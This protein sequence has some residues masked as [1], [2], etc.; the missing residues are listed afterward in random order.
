MYQKLLEVRKTIPYL[1]QGGHGY[2]YDY[3]KE[4]QLLGAI[5]AEMDK[6]AV[7]LDMDMLSVESVDVGV[8]AKNKSPIIVKGAK[9]VLQFTFT[10]CDNPDEKIVRQQILQNSTSDVQAIGGYKLME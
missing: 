3:T 4:S 9:A 6:Q 10:N 8:Y 5:R 7:F 2:G 1:K